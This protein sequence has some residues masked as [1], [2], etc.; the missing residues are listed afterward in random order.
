MLYQIYFFVDKERVIVKYK[1]LSEWVCELI[2]T[3]YQ[4]ILL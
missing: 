2:L 3:S 1:T 4:T